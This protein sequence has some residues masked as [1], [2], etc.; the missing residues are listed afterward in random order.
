MYAIKPVPC[1]LL[2]ERALA[3]L[4]SPPAIPTAA[5][6]DTPP[7]YAGLLLH[8]DEGER[9]AAGAHLKFPA[10][11]AAP[12]ATV[13]HVANTPRKFLRLAWPQHSFPSLDA[14]LHLR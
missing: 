4:P 7:A 3:P 10:D 2:F 14:W 5:A 9:W 1:D 11:L 12:G 6:S 13:R 8:S